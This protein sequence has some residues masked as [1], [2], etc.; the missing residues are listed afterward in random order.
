MRVLTIKR[1][2]KYVACMTKS[3]IY[4]EDHITGDTI[5]NHIPCRKLGDL[6]NGSEKTFSIDNEAAKIFVISDKL[7]KNF[8]N[9]FYQIPAGEED[10][11]LSGQNKFNL[12]NGNAFI[13][14]NNSTEEVL[15]NRKKNNNKGLIVLL[16]AAL[17]GFSFGFF[18]IPDLL[19]PNNGIFTAD[20]MSI[21]LNDEFSRFNE[22]GYLQIFAT[23]EVVVLVT[24]DSFADYEGLSENTLEEYGN[25]VI[26]NRGFTDCKLEKEND[27]TYFTYTFEN[28]D[29]KDVYSYK[30][31]IFKTADAFWI[32]QFATLVEDIE[33]YSEQ[34]KEWAS[35]ITFQN[36]NVQ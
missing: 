34:V 8:S 2:K 7:S 35:T 15:A 23:E 12:A 1:A 5:I 29:T 24:K 4:I 17:I 11:C 20:N 28:P 19:N 26:E 22:E 3:K 27:L 21:T 31:Y 6:K 13:F 16:I 32:V 14:D 30:S 18:S 25:L 33:A 36:E 9:D 10:V